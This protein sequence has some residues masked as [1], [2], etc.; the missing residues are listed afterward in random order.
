MLAQAESKK[1]QQLED[2]DVD[3]IVSETW[4]DGYRVEVN[5]TGN[6]NTDSNWLGSIYL[7]E[8]HEI[9]ENYGVLVSEGTDKVNFS[10]DKWNER[11]K[12]GE[13]TNTVLIV[14]GNPTDDRQLL[15]KQKIVILQEIQQQKKFLLPK[16]PILILL[17]LLERANSTTAKLYS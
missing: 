3:Y 14:D 6:S 17:L 1:T 2:V 10:G 9:R 8:G 5:V 12:E 16:L 11:L 13:V 15:Q 4:N 7:P